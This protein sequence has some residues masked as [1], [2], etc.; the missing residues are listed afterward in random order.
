M[1]TRSQ[2]NPQLETGHKCY[3]S[4]LPT[5]SHT[6]MT[7][8]CVGTLAKHLF[9]LICA[10][11]VEFSMPATRWNNKYRPMWPCSPAKRKFFNLLMA[12]MAIFCFSVLRA[13]TKSRLTYRPRVHLLLSRL[14][15]RL[16]F[17]SHRL[18]ASFGS[19]L[20]ATLNYVLVI[21]NMNW[22]PSSTC[23]S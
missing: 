3:A 16:L 2:H 5:H 4:N 14:L 13:S 21:L 6:H 23:C 8:Q 20:M 15:Q 9:A 1:H 22:L 12:P 7:R 17:H 19:R 10:S 18:D 11:F